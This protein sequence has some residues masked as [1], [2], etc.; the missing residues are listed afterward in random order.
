MP[1]SEKP[2]VGASNS[3]NAPPVVIRPILLVL[4][5]MNQRL[6]SGPVVMPIGFGPELGVGMEMSLVVK[7]LVVMIRP[8]LLRAYSVNQSALSGP[9]VISK[10]PLL[11]VMIAN[12]AMTLP[13]GNLRPIL[14]ALPSV[15]HIAPS[16]P[17]VMPMAPLLLAGIGYSK[18]DPSVV[19]RPILL[20]VPPSVN[21]SAPS[22]PNVMPPARALGVGIENW[23]ICAG[24]CPGHAS[25]AIAR[26][27]TAPRAT[28]RGMNLRLSS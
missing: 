2:K 25:A 24:A 5:S 6:P 28:R 21:H 1:H 15:N 4:F 27:T 20:A 3:A 18:N 22:G 12:S 8:I 23:V 11:F 7:G 10:G 9:T 14:L 19:I 26:A 17:A 13:V 16:G